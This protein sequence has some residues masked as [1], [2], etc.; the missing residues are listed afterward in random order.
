M[1]KK[2][3][4][5]S[6]CRFRRDHH[7]CDQI[8]IQIC[9]ILIVLSFQDLKYHKPFNLFPVILVQLRILRFILMHIRIQERV[10]HTV[11]IA[12][13]C[14]IHQDNFGNCPLLCEWKGHHIIFIESRDPKLLL[15]PLFIP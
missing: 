14:K 5:E 13:K 3:V 9:Q 1:H 2:C 12:V 15:D 10:V 6:L 7:R 11:Q 4:D 8:F